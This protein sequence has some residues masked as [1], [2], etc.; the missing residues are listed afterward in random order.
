[1]I[2]I[3]HYDDVINICG[4]AGEERVGLLAPCAAGRRGDNCG[5]I[6]AD[7][8]QLKGMCAPFLSFL[9]IMVALFL[10]HSFAA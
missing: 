10:F 7:A 9:R 1:M 6:R 8:G 2:N 4:C 5:L 3:I